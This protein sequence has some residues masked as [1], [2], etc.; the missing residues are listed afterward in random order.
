MESEYH[1]VIVHSDHGIELAG[2]KKGIVVQ[3]SGCLPF[4]VYGEN[5]QLYLGIL[6]YE[7]WL[8]DSIRLPGF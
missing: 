2:S 5:V 7:I 4:L 8:P 6:D 1:S 3:L